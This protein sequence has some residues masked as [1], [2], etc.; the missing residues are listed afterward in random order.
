MIRSKLDEFK[1][2]D[3]FDL[4]P[5]FAPSQYGNWATRDI[6]GPYDACRILS[7][8]ERVKPFVSFGLPVPVDMFLLSVG[9]APTRDCT[10]IGGLPFWPIGRQWPRSITGDF[11]PFLAQFNFSESRDI[12]GDLPE[13]LLLLF[14]HADI[15]SSIV[16]KWQSTTCHARLLDRDDMPVKPALPCFYGMRWRTESYPD[17]AY[18]DDP[19]QLEDGTRVSDVWFVCELLGMQISPYPFFPRWNGLPARTDR[20][21]CSL[22]SIFPIA[23]KPYSFV[24]HSQPLTDLE[25]QNLYLDLTEIKG[26]AFGVACVTIE[27]TGIPRVWFENL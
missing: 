18:D 14:G 25:A 20:A 19:I 27:K 7:V 22:C 12:T 15:P 8:R 21:L 17:A 5:P 24:N 9:E 3:W 11:L 1:P 10:K 13:N 26:D 23:H 16:A 2:D 6:I 4:F